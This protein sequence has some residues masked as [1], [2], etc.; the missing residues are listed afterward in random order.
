[1]AIT[2][3]PVLVRQMGV[4]PNFFDVFR[5]VTQLALEL[6]MVLPN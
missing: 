3:R 4:I 6:F 2:K 5:M 1:M